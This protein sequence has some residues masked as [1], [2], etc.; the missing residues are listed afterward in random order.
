MPVNGI[1]K[2]YSS[3]RKVIVKPA[4]PEFEV[5][6]IIIENIEANSTYHGKKVDA[7]TKIGKTTP[8]RHCKSRTLDI[9]VFC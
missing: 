4:D 6:E 3:E 9:Q 2:I 7:G 5:F 1:L 8:A